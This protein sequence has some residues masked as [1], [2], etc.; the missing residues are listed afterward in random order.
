LAQYSH[1]QF[2]GNFIIS[3]LSNLTVRWA[4][5]PQIVLSE[6][7]AYGTVL[8]MFKDFGKYLATKAKFIN[9]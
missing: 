1:S 2:Q 4:L 9:I 6:V 5:E 7:V 8:K 3:L